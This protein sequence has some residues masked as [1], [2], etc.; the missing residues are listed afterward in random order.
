[1]YIVGIGA[2]YVRDL[3][4][5]AAYLTM[6][7]WYLIGTLVLLATS[8]IPG[9]ALDASLFTWTGNL[10]VLVLSATL[11]VASIYFVMRRLSK[12]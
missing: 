10:V 1:M 12:K 3:G 4:I 2:L 11:N 6:P 9:P 5:L 8:I 7:A